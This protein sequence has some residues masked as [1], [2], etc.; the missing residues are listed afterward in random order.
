MMASLAD[1]LAYSQDLARKYTSLN[2]P[3]DQTLGE[4]VGDIGLGFVPGIGQAQAARDFERSRRDND[5]LG[6]GLS[7]AGVLPIV[8]GIPEAINKGKKMARAAKLA[9]QLDKSS[10]LGSARN[11]VLASGSGSP[12][13]ELYDMRLKGLGN[14]PESE[15]Y[16]YAGNLRDDMQKNVWKL[17]DGTYLAVQRPA[18]MSK[19]KP[20][21]VHAANINDAI[22]GINGKAERS[23][24]AVS[25]AAKKAYENSLQ[26]LLE[27]EFGEGAF[28]FANSA[29]SESR[30]V[31]NNINGVKIRISGHDLPLAYESADIDLPL[32]LSDKELFERIKNHFRPDEE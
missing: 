5:W 8:G 6:M 20:M 21:Y 3:H 15:L 19:D 16:D 14:L 11:G 4:T 17:N 18:W 12:P 28:S 30:Y 1:V 31:T 32:G 26:G 22:S 13:K 10:L 27:K 24:R 29:R 7:A 23:S 25:A 2:N 9:E